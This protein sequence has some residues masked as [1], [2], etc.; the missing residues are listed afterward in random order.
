MDRGLEGAILKRRTARYRRGVRSADWI[1]VK[2]LGAEAVEILR[3]EPGD[4]GDPV[5]RTVVRDRFGR[6]FPGAHRRGQ[7]GDPPRGAEGAGVLRGA[8]GS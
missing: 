8:G 5:G 1:K 2:R 6:E 4:T 3:L 7:R